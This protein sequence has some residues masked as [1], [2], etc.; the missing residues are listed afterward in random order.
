MSFKLDSQTK[1]NEYKENFIS[2]LTLDK[3]IDLKTG[4]WL[5]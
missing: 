3:F 5:K 2:K 1:N 4:D